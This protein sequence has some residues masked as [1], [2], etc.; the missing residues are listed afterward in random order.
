MRTKCLNLGLVFC[1][2]MASLLIA[3]PVKADVTPW[4][5]DGFWNDPYDPSIYDNI[6]LGLY[7]ETPF[8]WACQWNFG[9]GTTYNQCYVDHAKKYSSDGDYTVSVQVTNTAG[10][11]SSTSRV[12]S[13]RTHDVAITKFTVPQNANVGQTRQISVAISNSRYTERV[14]VELYKNDTIWVGTSVQTV[15]PRTAN[16]TTVF[17]FKYTFTAE[18]ALVGKVTFHAMA[19][20]LDNGDDD[21]QFDNNV[22]SLPTRVP[23]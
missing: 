14:Q 16:R 6:S 15:P 21:W 9:D 12:L 20:I 17:T 5:V 1:L 22:Y 8:D 18:D 19:F 13:V 23:R 7:G 11:I 3:Y 2:V 4:P 10:E